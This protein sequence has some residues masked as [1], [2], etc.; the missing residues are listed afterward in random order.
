[1]RPIDGLWSVPVGQQPV[2]STVI[3]LPARHPDDEH[4]IEVARPAAGSGHAPL[5]EADTSK[6]ADPHMLVEHHASQVAEVGER[7]HHRRPMRSRRLTSLPCRTQRAVA[8]INIADKLSALIRDLEATLLDATIQADRRE[9]L[10]V[11]RQKAAV[12]RAGSRAAMADE[13]ARL[14]RELKTV[15]AELAHL[16]AF[17]KRGRGSDAVQAE[18]ATTEATRDDLR[19]ALAKLVQAEAFRASAKD[20]EAKLTTALGDWTKL[21]TKP[22][23][24]QRQLLR[25]LVPDRIIV[26]P[27]VKGARKWI[28][29]TGSLIVAPIISGITPALGDVLPDDPMGG[30]WWPQRDS[31]PCFSHDHVFANSIR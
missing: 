20:L 11:L 24:Q 14:D 3:T 5:R 18:L 8:R 2:T 9:R 6:S 4:R 31:N 26:T 12:K 17:I 23:P 10:E 28:D 1:M 29:W 21:G 27:Y 30:R 16:V 19:L 13:R 7:A 22:I 25:K 15:E